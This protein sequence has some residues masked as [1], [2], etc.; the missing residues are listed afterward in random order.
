M[1]PRIGAGL[2]HLCMATDTHKIIIAEFTEL[3]FKSASHVIGTIFTQRPERLLFN[4]VSVR[5]DFDN[6]EAAD[7]FAVVIDGFSHPLTLI[8]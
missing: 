6:V 1:R 3:I 8:Q 7:R 4:F 5:K 2:S